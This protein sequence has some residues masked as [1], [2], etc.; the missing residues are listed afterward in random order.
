MRHF[1]AVNNFSAAREFHALCVKISRFGRRAGD[2]RGEF[3]GVS[4]VLRDFLRWH[5]HC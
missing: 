4:R 1:P 5:R 2:A 3:I